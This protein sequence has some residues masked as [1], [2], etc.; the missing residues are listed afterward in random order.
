MKMVQIAGL[1]CAMMASALA[2]TS[3]SAYPVQTAR[4]EY[5]E[6]RVYSVAEAIRGAAR[7][8]QSGLPGQFSFIV[9]G[10]GQDGQRVYLNSDLDYRD[11][12][13]LTVALSAPAAARL[14]EQLGG[15]PET[16]LIGRT[17]VI[18][19]V[20][21]RTRI[22]WLHDGEPTGDYYFQTHISV[23]RDDQIHVVPVPPAP[24]TVTR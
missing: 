15:S 7:A 9:K 22:N 2:S 6:P 16:A 18:N 14:A 8:G 4:P 19:G 17:I 20:A 23:G 10:G 24:V 3:T 1:V 5:V 12:G 11:R 13:T 21:R